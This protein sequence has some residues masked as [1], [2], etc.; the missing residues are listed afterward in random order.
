VQTRDVTVLAVTVI[1][2]DRPGII[3]AVAAALAD[4]GGNIEDSSMTILRGRFAMTLIVNVPADARATHDAVAPVAERL[5]L[6]VTVAEAAGAEPAAAAAAHAVLSVHGA[7]HP[8]IL[9]AVMA[10]VAGHGGNVTDLTT[11][12]TGELYVI[13]ADIDLRDLADLPALD[14]DL[15]IIADELGVEA[16]IRPADPDVL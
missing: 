8:G 10:V 4:V 3:A 16:V 2:A 11:R 7:D 5:G 14:A 9:S 12:L 15:R 13:V 6:G 1:G